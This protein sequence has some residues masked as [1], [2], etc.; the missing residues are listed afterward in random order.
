MS[1]Q[2]RE[3]SNSVNGSTTRRVEASG[4]ASAYMDF[5]TETLEPIGESGVV[6]L[7]PW[8]D[9]ISVV[10]DVETFDGDRV[11][12]TATLSLDDAEELRDEL[13]DVLENEDVRY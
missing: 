12:T 1:H 3:E 13:D 11:Q 6:E 9:E 2:L 7:Q 4:Y 10:V 8:G 5:G